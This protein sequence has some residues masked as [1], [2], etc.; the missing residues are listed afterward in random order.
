MKLDVKPEDV[1]EYTTD[2]RGRLT[3]GAE[4]DNQTVEI[5]IL[6]SD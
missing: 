6:D 5:A 2:S 3:L 1:D 4:Y